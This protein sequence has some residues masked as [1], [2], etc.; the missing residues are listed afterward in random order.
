[1]VPGLPIAAV[2]RLT[3]LGV[4]AM[5]SPRYR[6][7][8]LLVE[9][10]N[11][12]VMLDGGPGA[13][14][15]P[16]QPLDAWLVTDARGELMREIRRLA[17]RHGLEPDV[18]SAGGGGLV[19]EPKRV[20]H[21]NHPTFGYLLEAGWR[22]AWAP[23]FWEFPVWAGG[24]DLLFAEA[25]GWDRPIRFRGGV[26]GHAAALTVAEDARRHGV[27]RLILAHIGRPSIRALDAGR[28]L[29]FGEVGVEGRVYGRR[30]SQAT[31]ALTRSPS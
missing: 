8:G 1:V 10:R 26:G 28:R 20:V 6:P 12:R 5:A 14:P 2:V 31:G 29:P 13:E 25:A 21:T 30:R 9:H 7:A 18:S 3:L 22:A 24:V 19:V 11:R 16:D 15:E 27:G 23:E 17:A 4:G